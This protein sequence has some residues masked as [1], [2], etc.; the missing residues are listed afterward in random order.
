MK[1]LALCIVIFGFLLLTT[2]LILNVSAQPLTPPIVS[3]I[4]PNVG[5]ADQQTA[6]I[7]TGQ[8]FILTSTA[9]LDDTPLLAVTFVD[10]TTLKARVPFGLPTGVYT[11]TVTNPPS[12]ILT[13]A[14]TVTAG[15]GEWG[16][17][18]PYGGRTGDIAIHPTSTSTVYVAVQQSG[19]YRTTN[20]GDHWEQIMYSAAIPGGFVEVWSVDPTVL[21]FGREDGLYRSQ[22]GGDAGSWSRVDIGQASGQAVALAIAPSD[23][24]TMYCSINNA[25]F[26]SDDGGGE[27]VERSTGL[28]SGP[29][30]LAVDTNNAAVAYTAFSAEGMLYKTINA[31]QSWVMLPFSIPM[32]ISGVGGINAIATDPYRA[33]TLWLGTIMQ[34]LHLSSDGGQT[35]TEV[36]SLH[37]IGHQSGFMSISFDPNQDR[38]F[39]GVSGPNDAIYYSDDAGDSWHGL[40]LNNQ[41]GTDIAVAP[42]DSNTIYTTWAGVRKSMDGGQSWMWLSEGIAAIQPWRIAVSPQ[43]PQ[44]VLTVA[45]ADGAFGTHNSGNEWGTYPISSGGESH[46]YGAVTFDPISPTVVYVGGT[47]TVFKTLD[48]GQSWQATAEMPLDGLPPAYD[49]ANPLFLAVHPLTHTMIYAGVSFLNRGAELINDGALYYSDNSGSNWTRLTATGPISPVNRV[50]FAPGYPEIIYLGTG[51]G[52]HWCHGNGI[53]RSQDGGQTWEHPESELNG[54]RV[55]ALAVHPEN[56]NILLAGAWSDSNDGQGIYRSIDGGDSWELSDDLDEREER[57][58]SDVAY[59]P[60][61]PQIVYAATHGGLRISFN[62]GLSWQ[63]YLGAMGQL[64]MTALTVSHSQEKTYLYVGTVG[65]AVVGQMSALRVVQAVQAESVMGAGIY[66]GHSRWGLVYLPLVVGGSQ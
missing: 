39:V 42:G 17:G 32:T 11:L 6:V 13:N 4:I 25:L 22:Q 61:N 1:K 34:G 57:K 58:V 19:L 14:F 56:P 24:Y 41:G 7:I 21:F 62:G 53:W 65:G 60:A 2:V 26:Y 23:P 38:I 36:M 44:R 31:G 52:C 37:T 5:S 10:S 8:G 16:S 9:Y 43:D 48:D 29:S 33:D 12:G 18:G 55:L 63:A 3:T 46:Q 28:P 66:V 40:G 45:G 54:L 15:T 49:F 59:D 35:F 27:W 47:E 30:R 50:V 20:G 51:R 64:P